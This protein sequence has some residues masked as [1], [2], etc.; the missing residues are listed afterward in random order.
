[1]YNYT[2][3][4]IVVSLPSAVSCFSHLGDKH[5]DLLH[6]SFCGIFS[7]YHRLFIHHPDLL[8]QLTIPSR[9]CGLL[10]GTCDHKQDHGVAPTGL[11]A[12]GPD[13]MPLQA[14][15]Q[16]VPF[17]ENS[18]LPNSANLNQP[19]VPS[20]RSPE[21]TAVPSPILLQS[22]ICISKWWHCRQLFLTLSGYP[23]TRVGPLAEFSGGPGAH[24]DHSLPAGQMVQSKGLWRWCYLGPAVPE[25]T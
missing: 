13:G 24:L 19:S 3:D 20:G 12:D 16:T 15:V 21:V 18:P 23:F 25:I 10:P 14:S 1:M 7:K 6:N 8:K 17:T 9:T 11:L 4:I 22:A 2:C 5:L